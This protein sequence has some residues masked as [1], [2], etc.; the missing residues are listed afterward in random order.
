MTIRNTAY[1]TTACNG[2][3]VGKI[4]HAIEDALVSG[5]FAPS[6]NN[7][8]VKEIN[9][10]ATTTPVPAF[11]HPMV[12]NYN[13]EKTVVVD[14]RSSGK[15]DESN[16]QFKVRNPY[17]YDFITLYGELNNFWV[18]DNARL[19]ASVSH[20]PTSLYARWMSENITRRFGLNPQDQMTIAILAAF[21]YLGQFINDDVPDDRELQRLCGVISK[22][23]FVNAETVLSVIDK[24]NYIKDV[25]EFCEVLKEATGNVRLNELSAGVLMT[26]LKS[27]WYGTNASELVAVAMEFPPA[28]VLLTYSSYVDRSYKNTGI[29]KMS[30]RDKKADMESFIKSLATLIRH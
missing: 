15:F 1:E 16:Y 27:S 28:W 26:L 24:R 29:A 4:A 8:A 2:F 30:I 19:L 17:E 9:R 23:V 3:V 11:F 22:S 20:L 7:I 21:F 25:K 6:K 5:N 12:V 10:T 14:V 18:K 13:G